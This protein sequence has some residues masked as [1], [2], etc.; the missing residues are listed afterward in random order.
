M[1]K[2]EVMSLLEQNKNERGIDNW[3][4][5]EAPKCNYKSYGMGL[6]VHRKLAKQVGKNHDLALELWNSDYYDAKVISVLI[7]DPKLITQ[8]QM[9]AQVEDIDF[10]Y[11]VHVYSA[12]GA[13]VAKTPFIAEVA[14]KWA[15]SSNSVK[16]RCANGFVYELS[17]LKTKKAPDDAYFL[18]YLNYIETSFPNEPNSMRMSMAGALMGIGKRNIKLNKVALKIAKKMGPVPVETGKS[19]CEP[20]DVTKHLESDYLKKKFGL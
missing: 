13:P 12:C 20:F 16:R 17:K 14:L 18:D 4:E 11:M 10:G 8:E 7:D 3:N 19:K 1:N 2:S 15:K 5:M 9:E 6:T